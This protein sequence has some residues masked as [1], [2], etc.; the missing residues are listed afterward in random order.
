MRSRWIAPM[1][2][3]MVVLV[4]DRWTKVVISKSLVQGGILVLM[5]FLNI[6]HVGNRGGAF[7]VGSGEPK[8]FIPCCFRAATLESL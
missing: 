6:V 3:A 7:G 5:P 1:T 4:L 8:G 2:I